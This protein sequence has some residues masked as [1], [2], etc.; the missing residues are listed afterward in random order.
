MWEDILERVGLNRQ[1]KCRWA[2][3]N[4]GF[5][6]EIAIKEGWGENFLKFMRQGTKNA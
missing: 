5:S 2:V 6:R 3:K 4:G 1:D